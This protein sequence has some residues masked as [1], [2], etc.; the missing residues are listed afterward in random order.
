M[1]LEKILNW[2]KNNKME[3]VGYAGSLL[4]IS[5]FFLNSQGHIIGT[6][7]IYNFMNL[8]GAGLYLIYCTVK[9]AYPI[10]ILEVFW[11]G[12]AIWALLKLV[13]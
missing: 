4:Y 5:A 3:F 2:C 10:L 8:F 7:A 9:K 11:G 13:F 1:N 12:F 6:G